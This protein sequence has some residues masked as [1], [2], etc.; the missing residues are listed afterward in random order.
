[1]FYVYILKDLNN[2]LYFGY[3]ADLRKRLAEHKN[4]RNVTTRK[5]DNPELV[6]YE[7]YS[8]EKLAR[9]RETKLKDFG[10]SYTGLIKRLKLK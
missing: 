1:M 4:K 8:T 10:S 3:T 6:Y 5:M 9:E 2:K 7:A